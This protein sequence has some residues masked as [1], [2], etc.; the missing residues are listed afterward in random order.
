M[1]PE[2]LELNEKIKTHS[3]AAF[4]LLSRRGKAIYFP[5]KG[6]LSQSADAK[7]KKINATIGT[8]VQ[9]DGTP[10]R[11]PSVEKNFTLAPADVFPYAPSYGRQDLR[12]KWKEEMVKK[13]C[14]LHAPFSLPVVANGLTHG[15][16][17][18]GYLFADE[19]DEII[20]PDLYWEN[21]DLVFSLMYGAKLSTFPLFAEE[22]FNVEGLRKK[23]VGREKTILLLNFPN[24][25]TGYSPSVEERKQIT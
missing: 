5:A 14:S 16:S 11:L 18:A 15:L 20:L 6:I 2:A 4:S 21:Y 10:M 22:K 17:I 12:M 13:N 19:G 23:L 8:A 1:H 3:L 25:P 9:D 7:G 24:N